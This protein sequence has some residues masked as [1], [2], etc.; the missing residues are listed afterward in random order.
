MSFEETDRSFYLKSEIFKT[1]N[2]VKVDQTDI[3][4]TGNSRVF[5]CVVNTVDII[6]EKMPLIGSI[7]AISGSKCV[8]NIG[9]SDNLE[10]GDQIPVIMKD[11]IHFKA[12]ST[13]IAFPD[14]SVIGKVTVTQT[15]DL[16]SEASIESAGIFNLINTGDQLP[17]AFRNTE[18]YEQKPFY[19]VNSVLMELFRLH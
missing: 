6:S 19:T 15:D 12:D 17:F 14:D 18:T 10:A 3:Q 5:T 8:I 9:K 13:E 16:V 4:R 1:S 7:I 2:G 11:K